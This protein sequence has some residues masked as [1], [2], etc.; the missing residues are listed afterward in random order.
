MRPSAP[1]IFAVALSAVALL[2]VATG[3]LIIGSPA[4]I[5]V[6][7]LDEQ[8]VI[9]LQSLLGAIAVYNRGHHRLPE[10]LDELRQAGTLPYQTLRNGH[11]EYRTTGTFTYELCAEFGAPSEDKTA[12]V[13]QQKSWSHA[14]GRVCFARDAR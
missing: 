8:R 5:R 7:R 3:L 6:L 13:W 10:S 4:H 1:V 9:E 14:A 2:A 12:P 11:Y